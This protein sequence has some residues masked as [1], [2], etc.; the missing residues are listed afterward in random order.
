MNEKAPKTCFTQMVIS[1]LL[2]QALPELLLHNGIRILHDLD[3][4]LAARKTKNVFI[5]VASALA[6]KHTLTIKFS[7]PV[8]FRQID[9]APCLWIIVLD[10]MPFE[11]DVSPIAVIFEEGYFYLIESLR[12]YK[13]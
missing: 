5:L 6:G 2:I 4:I 11:T 8:V 3:F 12:A 10:T 13:I 9:F 7:C 1:S